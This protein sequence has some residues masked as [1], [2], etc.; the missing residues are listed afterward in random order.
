MKL[1]FNYDIVYVYVCGIRYGQNI[2]YL[3]MNQECPTISSFF[4]FYQERHLQCMFQLH[5]LAAFFFNF[6]IMMM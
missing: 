4:L 5:Q 6:I 3:S 2:H 1:I